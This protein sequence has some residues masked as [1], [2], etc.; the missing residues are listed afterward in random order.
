[1]KKNNLKSKIMALCIISGLLSACGK[2]T[3][4]DLSIVTEEIITDSFSADNSIV[5]VA[6]EAS[7]ETS[8]PVD[9]TKAELTVEEQTKGKSLA[10]IKTEPVVKALDVVNIRDKEVDGEVIGKL[11]TDNTLETYGLTENGMYKVNY[12]GDMAYVSSEYVTLEN[13]E[14]LP[15]LYNKIVYIA[16]DTTIFT[17][18]E[19]TEQ[20]ILPAN[21]V[22]EV[23]DETDEYYL[24]STNDFI[25]YIPKTNTKDLTGTFVVVDLSDQTLKLYSDNNTLIDT[26]VV[27][28]KPSTPTHEG[29]FT[30]QSKR[31]NTWLQGKWYVNRFMPFDGGIGLHDAEYYT[32]E[33][34]FNHGWR[35][36]DEFGGN[37][38][39]VNGSH[40]CVNMH[41]DDVIT[42]YELLNVGDTVIVKR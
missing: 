23:Y 22:C 12:N 33:D 1:M 31:E 4:D 9:K 36:A 40:G 15:Y 30:I 10:D 26:L 27:T 5:G 19:L 18:D 14:Y 38:H 11:Y 20:Q 16:E 34:G 37:T 13:V 41:H 24:V 7:L 17:N 21:E 32:E 35:T 29:V 25:G 8:V 3:M 39:L 6:S 2:D 42:A 28:G